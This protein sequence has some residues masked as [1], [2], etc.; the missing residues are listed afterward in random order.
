M[1]VVCPVGCFVSAA[2]VLLR[3]QVVVAAVTGALK[4]EK[5]E[6]HIKLWTTHP[7]AAAHA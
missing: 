3:R 2:G 7:G 6:H 1:I 4:P 5:I